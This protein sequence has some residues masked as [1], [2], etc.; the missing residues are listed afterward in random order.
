M[1]TGFSELKLRQLDA[2][3]TRWRS[4]DLPPRPPSGWIKAVRE[5][6]GMA[7]THLAHRLG[8]NTSTVTRLETSEA[9]DTI[10]LATLRRAA[11]ALG[12]ELQYALVPRQSLAAMLES[13][14]TALARRQMAS[15]SHTMAL[16]AQATAPEAVDTQTRALAES[17]LKGSRRALWR[18][19]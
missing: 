11:E 2:A 6:L 4:A 12:C 5:S 19:S 8:V 14:A 13:R 15:V 17:L 7:A 16:E 1:K 18:E 9:D 10:T 3:L